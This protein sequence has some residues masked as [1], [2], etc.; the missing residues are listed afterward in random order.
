MKHT[1]V[2]IGIIATLGCQPVPVHR[3]RALNQRPQSPSQTAANTQEVPRPWTRDQSTLTNDVDD[4]LPRV[5]ELEAIEGA[6]QDYRNGDHSEQTRLRCGKWMFFYESF[7]TVGI[8]SHLLEFFQHWYQPYFGSSFSSMGFVPNPNSNDSIPI[9]LAES[10]Q[11]MGSIKIHAFTCAS[12]HFGQMP[13]GRYAVGYP[14]HQLDYGRF[15]ASMVALMKLSINRNED[16][17]H[18]LLRAALGETVQSARQR[19]GCMMGLGR[20]GLNIA[21]RGGDAMTSGVLDLTH[22]EQLRFWHLRTGTMDFLTKPMAD[23][24]V[25]TVSRILSLWNLPTP[26][27]IEEA[28][29]PHGLLSWTGIGK[30]L[31]DFLHGFVAISGSNSEWTDE[32]LQPLADYIYSLR[33]PA[34]VHEANHEAVER[35]AETFA[36]AGC[37]EC[38]DGP[39]GEGRE[40]YDFDDIG[41][42][43]AMKTIYNPDDDGQLCCGLD[44]AGDQATW[45]LK[46]PR[47]AGQRFR[48]R[49]LHNGSLDNLEQLLCLEPRPD[50]HSEAESA[51]GHRFGCD[52]LSESEKLDLI[53]Y[54][55]HL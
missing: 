9:G 36:Q 42:D 12:C 11:R 46:S 17:I 50:R 45:S 49:L 26:E 10:T 1:L 3:E 40:L 34:A 16:S 25:W 15:F 47:L 6:C 8:P 55:N 29:M 2:T 37:L 7:G 28:G 5:L 4:N 27:R 52:E 44:A 33:A 19:N 41:T 35:G 14:N 38:H 54:I 51:I 31:M 30:S 53:D 43:P 18:P 24:G 21:T 22:E 13:D 39:S 32:Q 48:T 23:D 20:L